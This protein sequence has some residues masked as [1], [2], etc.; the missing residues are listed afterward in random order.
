VISVGAAKS[1]D[2]LCT[3]TMTHHDVIIRFSY[4][5]CIELFGD[6]FIR[7]QPTVEGHMTSLA[8]PL[9]IAPLTEVADQ[10]VLGSVIA[11]LCETLHLQPL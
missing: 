6:N 4:D 10:I 1:N 7:I 5:F 2:L 9:N 11:Y 3:G 8:D